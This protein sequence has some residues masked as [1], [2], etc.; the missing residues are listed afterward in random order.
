MDGFLNVVKELPA[1]LVSKQPVFIDCPKKNIPF[2]YIDAILP[3]LLLHQVIILRPA[4]SQRSDRYPMFA[5][6]ARC[7]ACYQAVRLAKH[8]EQEA[9]YILGKIPRPFLALHLRF[10]PDMIAYSRCMYDSLSNGS[11]KL[12]KAARDGRE[13]FSGDLAVAWRR[14]GKCPLTPKETAFIFHALHIPLDMPIYLAAGDELL[15]REPF[16]SMY[17]N[18]Y[19]KNT[20][21]DKEIMQKVQGNS[22]AALDYYVS[23]NSDIYIAS[24]FGNMDKMVAAMRALKGN[25]KTLVLNRRAFAEAGLRGLNDADLAL[26]VWQTHQ[27]AFISGRGL[28][29]PDCFCLNNTD[30]N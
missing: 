4:A 3:S 22:K 17:T 13:P 20:L 6:A 28:A 9:E 8:L 30:E 26:H 12:I 29:L 1:N 25:W 16:L 15:E 21:L 23:L 14:R 18:I 5:K 27:E 24:Y 7:Q 10:E 11:L 19:T 2:D